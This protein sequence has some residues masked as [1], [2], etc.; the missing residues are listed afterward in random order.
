MTGPL[1][2]VRGGPE[3]LPFIMAT[4]RGEGYEHLVGRWEE[5]RH[6]AALADGSHAYFVGHEGGRPLGFVLLRFWNAPE[7]S[8]LVR[9]V[10]VAVPGQGDGPRL[11]SA[12]VDRVFED[13]DAH[14]LSIGLF[15]DNLRARRAYER[16]G[17]VAEGIARGSA[18]F[19]GTFR[20]E[21]VMAL[22]RPDW[23]QRRAGRPIGRSG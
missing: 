18:L 5:D 11:L 15:P 8:T 17:F 19:H 13:T 9:R 3:H 10:A 20:D 12:A 2:L 1:V 23:T 7:R 6:L 4:E 14:R 21:L 16:V 22:L